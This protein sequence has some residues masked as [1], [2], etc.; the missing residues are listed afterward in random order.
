M[1]A[2]AVPLVTTGI[3]GLISSI[4]I[5]GQ[6]H[7]KAVIA[8]ATALNQ[9]APQWYANVQAIFDALGKGSISESQA[10]SGIDTAKAQYYSQVSSVIKGQAP[11]DSN[12]KAGALPPT[13]NGPCTVARVWVEPAACKL[14]KL[15][16]TGG[17]F[18]LG[19]IPASGSF[20][21]VPSITVQY[22]KGGTASQL[23]ALLPSST[24]AKVGLGA[25][26][27]VGAFLLIR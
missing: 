11:A 21:G 26:G 6:A 1:A 12:C 18:T 8:E 10:L 16:G 24:A 20:R 4:N 5:F 2:A 14:K 9:A 15:I 22:T 25:L 3:K 17:T 13:C 27:L 7:Q 19:S 23:G